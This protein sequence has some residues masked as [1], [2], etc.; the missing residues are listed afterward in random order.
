MTARIQGVRDMAHPELSGLR[1]KREPR[2][3]AVRDSV[4]SRTFSKPERS[5]RNTAALRDLTASLR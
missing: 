1:S 2:T 5:A 3:R 4:Q